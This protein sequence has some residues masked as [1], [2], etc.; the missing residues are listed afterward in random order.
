[1]LRPI[2]RLLRPIDRLLLPINRL[3]HQAHRAPGAASS[4]CRISSAL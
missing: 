1:L 4:C 2:D 3:L